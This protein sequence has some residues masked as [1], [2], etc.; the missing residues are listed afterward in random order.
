M[1]DE[2]QAK[3]EAELQAAVDDIAAWPE[4]VGK[5]HRV[6]SLGSMFYAVK[7]LVCAE[8]C[9]LNEGDTVRINR[10]AP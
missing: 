1:S 10:I 6:A 4:L 7:V 5:V 9:N 8:S 3:I 2:K